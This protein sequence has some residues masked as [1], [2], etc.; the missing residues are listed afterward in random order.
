MAKVEFDAP[1]VIEIRAFA[2]GTEA[3]H[4][5]FRSVLDVGGQV[6]KAIRP[7]GKGRVVKFE[8]ND[9]AAA[10]RLLEVM[11]AALDYDLPEFG[12]A[13]PEGHDRLQ[14]S[15]MCAVFTERLRLR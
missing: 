6:S 7:D 5:G 1:S 10:G 11:A 3:V 9:R 2:H 13:A 4:P 8:M 14:L 12:P 15:S